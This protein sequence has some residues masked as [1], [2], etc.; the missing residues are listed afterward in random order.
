MPVIAAVGKQK[1]GESRHVG[2]V[3]SRP[4]R[5]KTLSQNQGK[6]MQTKVQMVGTSREQGR[7]NV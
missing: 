6:T 2:T 1:Q 3:S 4:G 5:V 7:I